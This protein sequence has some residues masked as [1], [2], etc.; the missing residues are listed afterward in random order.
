MNAGLQ[1]W[2]SASGTPWTWSWQAYPGVWLFIALLAAGYWRLAYGTPERAAERTPQR[3]VAA[4]AG[5]LLVWIALDWPVGALG[6]GYLASVH[7]VQYLVLALY[8]PPLLLYGLTPAAEAALARRPGVARAGR[9]LMHPVVAAVIFVGVLLATHAP[10]VTDTLMVTQAGS[11]LIDMLWLGSSLLFWWP[12]VG[13]PPGRPRLAPPFK[14]GQIFLGTVPHT[15]MAMWLMLADFPVYATYELAPPIPELTP[16]MDQQIA[17]G[18]M[19]LA[20]G[21]YVLGAVSMVF[22]RWHGLGEERGAGQVA[23][24]EPTA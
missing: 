24:R 11:F 16:K 4:V 5:L 21:L 13:H 23:L 14:I 12:I 19:L 15:P 1:W 10:R 22:F 18:L 8:A 17:A 20:G 9:V 3:T 7:M 2:C 6:G